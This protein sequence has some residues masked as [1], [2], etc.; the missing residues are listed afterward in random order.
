MIGAFAPLPVPAINCC[1]FSVLS[2]QRMY[3]CK[4]GMPLRLP[5]MPLSS[6]VSAQKADV[7]KELEEVRETKASQAFRFAPL[8]KTRHP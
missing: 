1:G 8:Q 2:E 7:E 6:K 3:L 4:I 5:L